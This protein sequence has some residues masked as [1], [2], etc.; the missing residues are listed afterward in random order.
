MPN[1]HKHAAV[2]KAWADGAEVQVRIMNLGD[3]VDM[4]HTPNWNID[5]DYRV[6]PKP[7]I[8]QALKDAY[9]KGAVIQYYND[10][11]G[12]WADTWANVPSWHEDTQ[13][14]VKPKTYKLELELT[15]AEAFVLACK[16]NSFQVRASSAPVRVKKFD[17][18]CDLRDIGRDLYRKF[19]FKAMAAAF[20]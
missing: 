10:G 9:A 7:H 14:R 16:V 1:K 12:V 19:D 4:K 20:E 15:E 11:A 3:W 17:P 6:K 18:N 8:H 13:Y 5:S 2:I